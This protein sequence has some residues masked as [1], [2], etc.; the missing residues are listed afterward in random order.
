VKSKQMVKG[1]GGDVDSMMD[2]SEVA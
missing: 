1:Q 2:V